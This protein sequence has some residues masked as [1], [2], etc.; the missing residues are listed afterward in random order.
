VDYGTN[1]LLLG[2]FDGPV[3]AWIRL[4]V[5][6][7]R[8]LAL[9]LVETFQAWAGLVL[10]LVL[11]EQV[12]GHPLGLLVHQHEKDLHSLGLVILFSALWQKCSPR[13]FPVLVGVGSLDLMPVLAIQE[14]SVEPVKWVLCFLLHCR[15]RCRV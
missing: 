1:H 15:N 11:V 8:L 14:A 13:V 3:L 5:T 10:F 6:V 9:D 4:L 7:A 2:L 12:D